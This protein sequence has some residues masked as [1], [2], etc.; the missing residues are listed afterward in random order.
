MFTQVGSL[1]RF[2]CSARVR[3]SFILTRRSLSWFVW[4]G[5]LESSATVGSI[6]VRAGE[7]L[8]PQTANRKPPSTNRNESA[9]AHD[10]LWRCQVAALAG[11][12]TSSSRYPGCR[13]AGCWSGRT[14]D[15]LVA[16]RP[17]Q[18]PTGQVRQCGEPASAT[19]KC[20]PS[21]LSA[22]LVETSSPV[23]CASG[24]AVNVERLGAT[25]L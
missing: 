2:V 12:P 7:A 17:S 14:V 10:R 15:T 8:A 9:G 4:P 19:L 6:P 20:S 11:W 3:A 5:Q 21:S 13:Q 1:S 23:E 24:Q 25:C 16:A 18:V 22:R